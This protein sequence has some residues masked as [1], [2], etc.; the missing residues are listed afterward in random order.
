MPTIVIKNGTRSL[1][2]TKRERDTID[3][4][5][6]LC[7]DIARDFPDA[8]VV[9]TEAYNALEFMKGYADAPPERDAG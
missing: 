5:R 1:K 9:A 8:A 4:V 3:N 7:N 2:L 6:R